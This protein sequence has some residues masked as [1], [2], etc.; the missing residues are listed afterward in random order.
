ME[1]NENSFMSSSFGYYYY[2]DKTNMNKN[3]KKIK[4]KKLFRYCILFIEICLLSKTNMM[5]EK[6]RKIFNNSYSNIIIMNQ[7]TLGQI[8]FQSIWI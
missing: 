7:K 3:T 8:F 6:A 1:K 5:R 4:A 2:N